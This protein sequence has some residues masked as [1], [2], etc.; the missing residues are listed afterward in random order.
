MYSTTQD[1]IFSFFILNSMHGNIVYS[2]IAGWFPIESY[3]GMHYI[4]VCYVYKLNAILLQTMESRENL[5]MVEVFESIYDNLEGKGHEPTV[6]VLNNECYH[7]VEYSYNQNK[8]ITN[9]LE[10]TTMMSTRM[11]LP[12]SPASDRQ[13]P[14]Q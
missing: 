1:D 12:S 13:F 8:Q 14:N 2:N 4:C 11:N 10:P 6:Q 7:V 9:V 5:S 3:T